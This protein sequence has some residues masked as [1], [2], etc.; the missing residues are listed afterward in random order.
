[1]MDK[2]KLRVESDEDIVI[3]S[4]VLQDAIMRVKDIT[5]NAKQRALTMRLTRFRHEDKTR[6]LRVL[7]G[8]RIDGITSLRAKGVDQSN[9]DALVVLLSLNFTAE[10]ESENLGG[11]LRLVF[12]GGGEIVAKVE[13][14]DVT[15]ADV[16]DDRETDKLPL[17][18]DQ[19]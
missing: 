7:S 19:T 2:L 4:S 6:N 12:A 17:H 10:T 3:L 11:A 13:C 15:L 5:Y 1:M 9:P 16:S 14:L 8:L 18:P